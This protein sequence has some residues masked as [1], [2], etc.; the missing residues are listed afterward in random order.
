MLNAE[1][2]RTLTQVGPDTAM[3]ALLRRYW[4]PVAGVS[5]FEQQAIKPLR[6]LGEDL[7]LYKDL[8]GNFGL[9]DRLCAHRRADLS[10][11]FVENCGLR[12]NYHGWLYDH[13]G[14]CT[15]QPFEDIANAKA[16]YKQQI[17]IKAYP[18]Q[19]K[20]GLLWAYLGPEPAPLLPDWEPFS[21][22]NGFV[23]IV[24]SELPCNWL[25]CQENS[26][27]PVH[28]E[29]MHSNWKLR[30]SGATGP[31]APTHLKV[32]FDE[33]E[34]GLTYKRVRSDTSEADPLWTVGRVCLWPNA[35]FLG[36]HFEWRIPVDD[37]NTLSI[38]WAFT[39]VPKESEPY[40]QPSIP[41]W[42][43]PIKDP[44]TGRWITSH[45]MNQ[46][47]VAWVGQGVV[48]DRADEHLATSDGGVVL[49]RKRLFEDL[50]AVAD[51]RDPRALIRDPARNRRVELPI[52]A[53][54]SLTEGLTRA[55]FAAH[56]MFKSQLEDYVFQAGQP[57][58]VRRAFEL[59]MG[60]EPGTA[61][62]TDAG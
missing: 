41:T 11:G 12:C 33:F 22:S 14:R 5:E 23:Q 50:K 19:Q 21:W 40:V 9:V 16:N 1:R 10:Y 24:V 25:Q 7:V 2:N 56:P 57:P 59:A 30:Q 47:F 28:F 39:R 49:L 51:G 62:F 18:V 29:W 34:F 42:H 55:Q 61:R 43:G 27:D 17:R 15:E 35:F 46:D 6:L 13:A 45:V 52:A 54:H 4:M 60:L 37:G 32:A 20:A 38:S 26:I 8:G 58:E 53:R 31:Y 44:A 3:G 36:D 48:A